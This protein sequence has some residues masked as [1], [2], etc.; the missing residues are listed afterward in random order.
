MFTLK[1]AN[2]AQTPVDGRPDRIT[3]EN[4][5]T[6]P[7]YFSTND[8]VNFRLQ[9]CAVILG[10][11]YNPTCGDPPEHRHHQGIAVTAVPDVA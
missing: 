9:I 6:N 8:R 5:R 2:L 11:L 3:S 10:N 7:T 4:N 1:T